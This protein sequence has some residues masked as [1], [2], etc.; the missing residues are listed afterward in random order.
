MAA[1][2]DVD[3]T[4]CASIHLLCAS[5]MRNRI[6]P[7]TGP[8]WSTCSP[9]HGCSGHSQVQIG[10]FWWILSIS[11]AQ[12][13]LSY[14]ILQV[15]VETWLPNVISGETLH[16]TDAGVTLVDFVNNVQTQLWRYDDAC[17]P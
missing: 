7:S 8:A 10:I 16:T 13:T 2:A 15:V 12:Y 3:G 1:A 5:T 6:F 14:L 11:L 4:M 9:V 17:T